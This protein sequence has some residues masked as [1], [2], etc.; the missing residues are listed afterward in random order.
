MALAAKEGIKLTSEEAEAFLSEAQDVELDAEVLQKVAG[1]SCYGDCGKNEDN[2][3][4]Q[5]DCFYYGGR[6]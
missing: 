3:N 1:G 6:I 4:W 2:K 5:D